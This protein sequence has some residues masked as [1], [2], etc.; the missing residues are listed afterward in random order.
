METADDLN[1]YGT[2]GYN[3]DDLE[4][5]V[6]LM[7]SAGTRAAEGAAAGAQFGIYGALIGGAAGYIGGAF[8]GQAE[9]DR[10][11]QHNRKV[12]ESA[13]GT[14]RHT[15]VAAV[16]PM[17]S[18]Q[19][20]GRVQSVGQPAEVNPATGTTEPPKPSVNGKAFSPVQSGGTLDTTFDPSIAQFGTVT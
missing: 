17:V 3:R 12:N 16:D 6:D 9:N 2:T 18:A 14:N 15:R 20:P 13:Y 1:N 8:E 4:E 10:I 5:N 7:T 11:K 19:I